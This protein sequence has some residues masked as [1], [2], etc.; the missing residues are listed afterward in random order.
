MKGH[1]VFVCL[2]SALI[3]FGVQ[4]FFVRAQA[5]P[6][7]GSLRIAYA[8]LVRVLKE[9]KTFMQE[10]EVMQKSILKDKRAL[11]E[12]LQPLLEEQQRKL[13]SNPVGSPEWRASGR[14]QA[15]LILKDIDEKS[16]LQTDYEEQQQ[17]IFIDAY[18]RI[19]D[20]VAEICKEQGYQLVLSLHD[21]DQPIYDIES[22]H[23]ALGLHS[24]IY[25]EDQRSDITDELIAR[26]NK[27]FEENSQ[28][29]EPEE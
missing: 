21:T 27:D 28:N 1:F 19:K 2:V 17:N 7:Q 20:T 14:T 23:K 5:E 18:S 12:E 3:A 9:D 15:G 16:G 8:D 10:L 22:I 25:F 4:F 11:E 29:T 6:E 24:V 26:L 13:R